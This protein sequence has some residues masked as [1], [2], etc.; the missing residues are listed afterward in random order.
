MSKRLLSLQE[1]ADYVGLSKATLHRAVKAGE[2]AY[3]LDRRKRYK[4][5]PSEMA[6]A[7][8]DDVDNDRLPERMRDTAKQKGTFPTA[9]SEPDAL[10]LLRQELAFLKEKIG[11]MRVYHD[12]ERSQMAAEIDNLR[13]R[14]EHADEQRGAYTR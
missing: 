14:L 11:D 5:E 1:A 9:Y 6:R 2:I 3:E 7:Y 4:I 10:P 13:E 8:P 12:R